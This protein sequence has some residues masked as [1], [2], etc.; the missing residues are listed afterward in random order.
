MEQ[1]YLDARGPDPKTADPVLLH[2]LHRY[3][4]YYSRWRQLDDI[5]RADGSQWWS[6]KPSAQKAWRWYDQGWSAEECDQLTRASGHGTILTGPEVERVLDYGDRGATVDRMR[7]AAILVS[8]KEVRAKEARARLGW[9]DV[10]PHPPMV[11]PS[12]S[13]P[14]RVNTVAQSAASAN[15]AGAVIL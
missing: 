6:L 7:G 2:R 9:P 12:P 10:V 14:T 15:S 8:A 11:I 5:L 3:R 1:A 13:A 4:A